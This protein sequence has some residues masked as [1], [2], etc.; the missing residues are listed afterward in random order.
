MINKNKRVHKD[1][2]GFVLQDF[3]IVTCT[4]QKK[5]LLSLSSRR[6]PHLSDVANLA[7]I[8]GDVEAPHVIAVEQQAP[9][10]GVVKA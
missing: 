7:A 8:V 6:P 3:G 4:W 9:R 1:G 5:D 10:R 2:L